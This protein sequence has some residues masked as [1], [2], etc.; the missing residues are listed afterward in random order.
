MEVEVKIRL[1]NPRAALGR[2]RKA[3]F[4]LQTRDT[5]RDVVFDTYGLAMR[6]SGRLLRLRR[7]GGSWL[8]TFKGPAARDRR[9]KVREEIQTAVADGVQLKLILERLGYHPIFMYEKRR[10]AFRRR[11]EPG[12]V[13]VD[14]TPIGYFLELEGPRRWIAGAARRL[15]FT[16]A[17]YITKSYGQLYFDYCRERRIRPSHML[18]RKV[19]L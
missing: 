5:E 12:L 19:P 4:V 14:H 1:K 13:T 6:H 11:G 15:G 3:G 7:H 9:Y 8:L 10:R 17:D 16:P 2:L 18:F